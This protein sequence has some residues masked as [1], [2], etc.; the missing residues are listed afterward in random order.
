MYIRSPPG[1]CSLVS[2]YGGIIFVTEEFYVTQGNIKDT[3][4]NALQNVDTT[5]IS[6]H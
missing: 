4:Y 1:L 2:R 6:I 3:V 5:I